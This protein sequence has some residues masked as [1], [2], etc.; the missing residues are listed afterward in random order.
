ML[1]TE[2]IQDNLVLM[3]N[4]IETFN[5]IDVAKTI[6]YLGEIVSLQSTATET[7]ASAKYHLLQAINAE[8]DRQAKLLKKDDIAPSIK[9]MRAD[10]MCADWHYIY[11]KCVRYSTN[12]SHTIDAVRTKI[13]YLKQEMENAKFTK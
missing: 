1:T 3:A 8:L 5:S 13:S 10:S 12:I 6:D 4:T 9:K 11:E 7:Q 2:Q